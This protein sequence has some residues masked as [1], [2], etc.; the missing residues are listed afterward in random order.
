M[1][2]GA[3][4]SRHVA[5]ATAALCALVASVAGCGGE[6]AS[7]HAAAPAVQRAAPSGCMPAVADAIAAVTH[8]ATVRSAPTPASPGI[9]GC[10]YAAGRATVATVTIDS[11]PQA[12]RRWFRAVV[13]TDQVGVWSNHRRALPQMLD[14]LGKGADWFPDDALLLSSD[15]PHLIRVEMRARHHAERIARAATAATLRTLRAT[16]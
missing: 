15:G 7:H 2:R 8:G 9:G 6:S 16:H 4:R 11:N 13:E 10:R 12:F 5:T 3:S 14:G 1:Q